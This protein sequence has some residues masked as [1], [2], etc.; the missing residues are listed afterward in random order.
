MAELLASKCTKREV[1][2][3]P[4]LT[5]YPFRIDS[6]AS[7]REWAVALQARMQASAQS[8]HALSVCYSFLHA[9]G[10]HRTC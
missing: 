7:Y 1:H 2:S 10:F 5:F 4:T 6:A 8:F 3:A 9:K